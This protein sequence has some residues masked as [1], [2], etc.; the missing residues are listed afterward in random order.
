MPDRNKFEM[1]KEP[2]VG[3]WYEDDGSGQYMVYSA[4][5]QQVDDVN[6]KLHPETVLTWVRVDSR[7]EV[8]DE[9]HML[10][11]RGLMQ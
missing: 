8:D 11:E 10:R 4:R 7:E 1:H 3:D 5:D 2:R 9:L 6:G